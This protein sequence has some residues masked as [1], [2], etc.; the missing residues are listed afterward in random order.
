ME[1]AVKLVEIERAAGPHQQSPTKT[2]AG[3]AQQQAPPL[4][5]ETCAEI[6]HAGIPQSDVVNGVQQKLEDLQ[7]QQHLLQTELEA[8][9]AAKLTLEDSF[10][11]LQHQHNAVHLQLQASQAAASEAQRR[12]QQ[13]E[14]A[15]AT[16]LEHKL[17][18]INSNKVI[19]DCLKFKMHCPRTFIDGI[20]SHLS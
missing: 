6:N 12:L 18:D 19:S 20:A 8:T 14:Q 2:G 9:C 1:L 16:E 17:R 10:A 7:H 5:Q 3:L 15:H 13:A 4:Q 11:Q